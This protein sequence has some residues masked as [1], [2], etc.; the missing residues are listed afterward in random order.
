MKGSEK[1]KG[2]N[3]EELLKQLEEAK[4]QIARL[5]SDIEKMQNAVV[6]IKDKDNN[7]L[8]E[9]W[10]PKRN[11]QYFF[12]DVNYLGEFCDSPSIISEGSTIDFINVMLNNAFRTREEC[13]IEIDL[14]GLFVEIKEKA[15]QEDELIPKNKMFNTRTNK[16]FINYDYSDCKLRYSS[17]SVIY[18]QGIIPNCFF[19]TSEFT[20][21]I[22]EEYGERIKTLLNKK[23]GGK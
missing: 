14:L 22:I 12:I 11:E 23:Y 18:Q 20:R 3:K 17:F 5:Q 13:E 10:F 6:A 7:S 4:N 21:K 8:P 19:K 15:L 1:L 16:Y 9:F 2:L